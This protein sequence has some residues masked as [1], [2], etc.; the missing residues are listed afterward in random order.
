MGL[1]VGAK[2][3]FPSNIAGLPTWFSIR[4]HPE[5]FVGRKLTHDIVIAKNKST[6]EKDIASVKNNGIY[7]Y[8]EDFKLNPK[9]WRQDTECWAI[10]YRKLVESV[11][12]SIKIRK[13]LTNMVYLGVLAE[14]LSIPS[15]IL[16]GALKD[17]FGDKNS[18]IEANWQALEAGASYARE[19]FSENPFP[20]RATSSTHKPEVSSGLES[21][22]SSFTES[23]TPS[24]FKLENQL[25]IDGNA[26]AALGAVAGGCTFLSWYPITPSSSL[27]ESFQE[28]VGALR[29]S[30]ENKKLHAV[31]QA[32]DELS[33]I[34]MV[35]G[36]GWAGSRAMTATSGPG[37]SLMAE[38]A[39]L[40]YFAEVPAVIWDV[41]RAGP[42]T[43]LPTRTMQGDLRFAAHISHGDVEHIVLIPSTPKECFDF[44][45]LAFDLAERVQ[46]LVIVLSDLDLGMNFSICEPFEISRQPYDRGKVLTAEDLNT[47]DDF[48]RYRDID[49]DGIGYRT[50]PGTP[51]VHAAY[52]TRGTGHTEKAAY[53]EDGPN[54]SA[55]LKR[56]ALKLQKAKKL[57]PPPVVRNQQGHIVE[58]Y[59]A[60]DSQ[61]TGEKLSSH[62]DNPSPRVGLITYGSSD[63][64]ISEVRSELRKLNVEVSDLRIRALPLNERILDFLRCHDEIYIIEQNRDAQM[65]DL[66]TQRFPQQAAKFRSVLNFDG[67]PLTA[68]FVV[69]EVGRLRQSQFKPTTSTAVQL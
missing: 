15:E 40:S 52:F 24:T 60:L 20:Y 54:Y 68:E 8:D 39:G 31:V 57:L 28:F 14:K 13:L 12:D 48:A 42:S 41:Q 9:D 33:A 63:F 5:G 19:H 26:A 46:T 32:E 34:S 16:K 10:P 43:G 17:Q 61:P 58:K 45:Q 11:S 21:E 29:K 35:I 30:K 53:S 67:L 7:I 2:N 49:G 4:V 38:A 66:L 56:L 50:L 69:S 22:I 62:S 65:R 51:H 64:V 25:F 18:V 27:A 1:P 37:L 44:A 55:L 23:E 6:A 36:A 3:L 47:V 59:E